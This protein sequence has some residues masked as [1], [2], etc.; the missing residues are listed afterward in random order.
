MRAIISCSACGLDRADL[1]TPC[2]H[3]GA[4]PVTASFGARKA[5]AV[6]FADIVGS[7]AM[8]AG[9]PETAHDLLRPA[10]DLMAASVRRYGGTVNRVTGDGVMALFG[11]PA[12]MED[13]VLAACCAALTTQAEMPAAAP[14][15]MVRIGI[16]AGEV[17]IYPVRPD[18]AP[19]LD[20]AGEVVH[21]AARLE[22]AAEPGTILVSPAV[23]RAGQG[24][25]T[26]L[27][28]GPRA[29]PGLPAPVDV[30]V[31][32]AAA[33]DLTRLEAAGAAALAPFT[34][35]AYEREMLAETVAEARAGRGLAL[36]LVGDAG[37]GKS[38][39][40]REFV[41]DDASGMTVHEARCLRWRDTVGFHPLKPVLRALLLLDAAEDSG[42]L[43]ARVA[44]AQSGWNGAVRD[45]DA[46]AAVLDQPPN[47]AWRG[48]DPAA[49]R[50]RMV[51]AATEA[52]LHLTDA[53]PALLVVDDVHWA[54]A[55][56]RAVLTGLAGAIGRLP[57]LLLLG[58]RP[59]GI[60][61]EALPSVQRVPVGPLTA[62]DGALLAEELLGDRVE[63][64]L[65]ERIVVRA[66]GNPLFIEAQVAA[67]LEGATENYLPESVRALLGTRIDRVVPDSRRVLETM[68][69][70]GEPLP[71]SLLAELAELPEPAVAHAATDLAKRGLVAAEGIADATKVACSHALV[72]DVAY[73]DMTRARRR[74]LHG[75]I[76]QLLEARAG[77]RA[78]EEAETLARHARL[79]DD[80]PRLVRFARAAG[81]RA[82]ARNA[83][84]EAVRFYD[85]ALAALERMPG[86]DPAL[87][88][89]LRFDVRPPLFRLGRI[90]ELRAR[91]EEAER[92]AETLGDVGRLGQ[93]LLFVSHHAWLAADHDAASAAADRA[94]A[95]AR[96]E[97]DEALALRAVFQRGLALYGLE[98]AEEAAGCMAQVAAE[99]NAPGLPGRYGLDRWLAVTALAYQVRA[100]AD[101][102]RFAEAAAVVGVAREMADAAVNPFSMI[103]V[104]IAEGWML[105]RRGEP[106]GAV[107]PLSRALE[108]CER[109]EA[110][111]MRPVAAGF[112]GAALAASS[113]VPRGIGH[114]ERS[115]A[116]AERMGFLFQQGLRMQLLK[117]AG[118][119]G[120]LS[121]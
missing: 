15:I 5:V 21:L 89:D 25:I 33:P 100:L 50:R 73:G 119:E 52:L 38:R 13:Y 103:F 27:P 41:H 80:L 56:T 115:V 64:G 35:R 107:L 117:I 88:V 11:A 30:F 98:R 46:L 53:G 72:Q 4:P 71:V 31:L 1:G 65:P 23:A 19:G 97:G 101:L 32:D 77:S 102:E 12:A 116:D 81:R 111:L 75:R 79:A 113:D 55:E 43:A 16:H 54:D 106:A 110:D 18:G 66:G 10:L 85:D 86:A 91:L 28:L 87:A 78:E 70:H 48:L 44:A 90:A 94:T 14:G 57:L 8:I 121:T 49:R 96:R 2:P 120:S 67:R 45:A 83:N 82:A 63:H 61:E 40:M 37:I 24:R 47:G 7:T 99:W 9:D 26:V 105:Y 3:C 20:A 92:V 114:L 36:A 42:A 84:R 69:A 76:G 29:L 17:M 60:E 62:A 74:T 95:L 68:A 104:D 58:T 112:L 6:L 59:E 108:M 109:A 34:G 39:L 118:G 51:A 22:K 93:L